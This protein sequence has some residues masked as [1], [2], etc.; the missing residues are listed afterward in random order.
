MPKH[1]KKPGIAPGF[2]SPTIKLRTANIP[3][4]VPSTIIAMKIADTKK[5]KQDG[6]K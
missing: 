6:S 3:I 2:L 5:K 1:H 4:P